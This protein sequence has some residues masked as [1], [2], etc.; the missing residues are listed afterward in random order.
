MA[1]TVKL[2]LIILML[3]Y[4]YIASKQKKKREADELREANRRIRKQGEEQRA[5]ILKEIEEL[6]KKDEL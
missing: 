3:I 6:Y 4:L 1:D 5:K 2:I